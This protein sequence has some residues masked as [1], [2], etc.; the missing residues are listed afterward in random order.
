MTTAA[1]RHSFPPSADETPR[2]FL[3]PCYV[4][5]TPVPPTNRFSDDVFAIC[6]V[7]DNLPCLDREK[8]PETPK[9]PRRPL[10]NPR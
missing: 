6:P 3:V 1:P 10:P 5:G 4:C 9:N 2:P 8:Q 7:Q